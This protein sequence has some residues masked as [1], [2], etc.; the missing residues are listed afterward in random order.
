[1]LLPR[2]ELAHRLKTILP[3]THNDGS[4]P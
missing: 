4:T 1:V 2:R 3:K